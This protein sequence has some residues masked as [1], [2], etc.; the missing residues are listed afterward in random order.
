MFNIV[1]GR[2][3][4]SFYPRNTPLQS[5]KIGV[6]ELF[7]TQL[8]VFIYPRQQIRSTIFKLLLN[9]YFLSICISVSIYKIMRQTQKMKAASGSHASKEIKL[10]RKWIDEDEEVPMESVFLNSEEEVSGIWR[11]I[12]REGSEAKRVKRCLKFS[13]DELETRFQTLYLSNQ[14]IIYGH[15]LSCKAFQ[16][17]GYIKLFTNLGSESY[18]VDLPKECYPKF[19]QEFYGNFTADNF[20]NYVSYVQDK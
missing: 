18:I 10:K 4:S 6:V 5:I 17:Y 13:Y 15:P 3:L 1:K 7:H 8:F 11:L 12:E 19:V 9:R 20:G 2:V 14:K 16:N